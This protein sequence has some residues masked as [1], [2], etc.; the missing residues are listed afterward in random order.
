MQP[1][2]A[3]RIET[4]SEVLPE[5]SLQLNFEQKSFLHAALTAQ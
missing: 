3:I 4:T 5:C 2:Q 1:H